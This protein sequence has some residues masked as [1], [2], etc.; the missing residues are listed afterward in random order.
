MLRPYLSQ[1]S[2]E[3]DQSH[4]KIDELAYACLDVT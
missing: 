2:F 1:Y 3:F 4:I